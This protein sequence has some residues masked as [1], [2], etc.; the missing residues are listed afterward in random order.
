MFSVVNNALGVPLITDMQV[1]QLLT[2]AESALARAGVEES[3]LEAELLLRGCLNLSRSR[4]FLMLDSAL[5]TEQGQT[6]AKVLSRRCQREPLQYIQGSCEFWSLDFAV[7]ESVLIPRPE[8]EFLL[9][10]VFSTLPDEYLE[11]K[12]KKKC[13]DLCTGS[14]VIAVVLAQELPTA[15]ILAADTSFAALRTAQHNINKHG[16]EGR[17]DL[18]QSDLLTGLLAV[19]LFDLIVTNPPYIKDGDLPG[20]EPEVRVWEPQLALSGGSTG[21]DIIKKICFAAACRLKPGGWLF[22]EIGSDL[23]KPVEE[24]FLA[25]NDFERIQILDDWSGRPRVLQ[26]KRIS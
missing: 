18:I 3:R 11:G 7:N 19:P 2:T 14:G 13:L 22:M 24:L 12:S 20:L 8:T 26:A 25:S 21:M 1:L 5:T 9:E 16:M 17:I 4:L 15:N 23:A 6:F 10:H